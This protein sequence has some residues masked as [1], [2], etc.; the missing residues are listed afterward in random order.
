M[1]GLLD[2]NASNDIAI[3]LARLD[4]NYAHATSMFGGIIVHKRPLAVA[5]LAYCQQCR[6]THIFLGH[7]ELRDLITLPQPDALNTTG[8]TAQRPRLA[9]MKARSLA[10]A[11]NQ[12]DVLVSTC[13]GR[14]DQVIVLA[15]LQRDNSVPPY[16]FIC[17]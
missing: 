4:I 11:G 6:V 13:Y 9:L 5:M 14:T 10:L 1:V 8:H 17:R 12:H 2:D 3:P 16:V 7:D 15:A